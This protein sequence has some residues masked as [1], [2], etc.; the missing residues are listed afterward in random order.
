MLFRSSD[1]GGIEVRADGQ[2]LSC[3]AWP[4]AQSDLDF[5]PGKGGEASASG[6]VPNVSK[7]GA[8]IEPR[9]FVTWNIDLLQMGVGGDNSWGAPVHDEYQIDSNVPRKYGFWMIPF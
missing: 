3:S 7:H 8:D 5:V 6:L 2:W 1:G 9:D 4:F